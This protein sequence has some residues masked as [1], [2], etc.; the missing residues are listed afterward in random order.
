MVPLLTPRN[1]SPESSAALHSDANSQEVTN[2]TKSARELFAATITEAKKR[3]QQ[4]HWP[5]AH[6]E[7]VRQELETRRTHRQPRNPPPPPRTTDARRC[8][9]IMP[10]DPDHPLVPQCTVQS[11]YLE[12]VLSKRWGVVGSDQARSYGVL[13]TIQASI[14]EARARRC[15]WC[16]I[17]TMLNQHLPLDKQVS[18][19]PWATMHL[20]CY[21]QELWWEGVKLDFQW[22]GVRKTHR[23]EVEALGSAYVKGKLR[24]CPL[25]DYQ[26]PDRTHMKEILG[27]L[28]VRGTSMKAQ[29]RVFGTTAPTYSQETFDRLVADLR[30]DHV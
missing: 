27:Q 11:P 14:Q 20:L 9:I 23:A 24:L 1:H 13:R 28:A 8:L 16:E 4:N 19:V 25:K 15:E 21:A 17:K 10:V 7:R 22:D 3:R 2:P 12:S 29:K 30:H 26:E 18:Q 6:I 5:E